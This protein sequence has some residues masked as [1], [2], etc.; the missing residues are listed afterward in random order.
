MHAFSDS[1]STPPLDIL[2]VALFA[3]SLKFDIGVFGSIVQ[4]KACAPLNE[5][6]D[7]HSEDIKNCCP[8]K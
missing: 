2:V 3:L 8:V 1:C 4:T 7:L 6:S 5:N